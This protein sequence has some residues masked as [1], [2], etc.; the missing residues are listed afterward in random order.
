MKQDAKTI[1]GAST[2]ASASPGSSN[3]PGASVS[4]VDHAVKIEPIVGDPRPLKK[5]RI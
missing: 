2:A 1:G 5:Q 3:V 4:G